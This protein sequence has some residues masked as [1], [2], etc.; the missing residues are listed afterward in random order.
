MLERVGALDCAEKRWAD[1]S[2]WE[3]L[4]VGLARAFVADPKL[5]V[6]D[7]LLDAL[8]PPATTEA[9]RLLRSLIAESESRCGVLMSVSDR[10]SAIY[11]DRA[12]SLGNGGRLTP[13]SGHHDSEADIIPLRQRGENG[14]SRR[15]G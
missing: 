15:V 8:G 10:D 5:V 6:V 1:L 9:S 11:A 14:G 13:T 3:Q 2:P 7:D 12:W 4:R